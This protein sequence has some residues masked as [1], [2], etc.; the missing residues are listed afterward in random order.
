VIRIDVHLVGE[1][2]YTWHIRFLHRSTYATRTLPVS[3][4]YTWQPFKLT[5]QSWTD[6]LLPRKNALNSTSQPG[7]V[8]HGTRLSFSPNTT[9]DIVLKSNICWW[10]CYIGLLG[11]YHQH[12]I[13]TFNTCSWGVS[14]SVLN[15]HKQGLQPWRCQLATSH[16]PPFLTNGPP[17]SN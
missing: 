8:A 4:P 17:L 10:T 9:I 6:S 13:S 12:V 15:W 7:W 3:S 16:S 11:P 1:T 5:Q 2:W 14:T